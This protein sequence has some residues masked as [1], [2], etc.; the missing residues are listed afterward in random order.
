[1][2]IAVFFFAVLWSSGSLP[3]QMGRNYTVDLENG[4]PAVGTILIVFTQANPSNLVGIRAFL[5][6][7]PCVG[8]SLPELP[9][10]PKAYVSF[11]PTALDG[12]IAAEP[13]H[14]QWIKDPV[15]RQLGANAVPQ[16]GIR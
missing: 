5:T 3:A 9:P 7:G 15:G 10:Y 14:Q 11:S 2:K 6:A 1:M 8:P 12:F 16:L 13:P 4:D